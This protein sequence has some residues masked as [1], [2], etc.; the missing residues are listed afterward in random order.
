MTVQENV[1]TSQLTF[2]PFDERGS[3]RI[4][5]HAFLPH[6]RQAGCTYF[7]TFRLADSIPKPVLREWREERFRWL[8]F[9][10]ID[11]RVEGW[12]AKFQKLST[13]ER[14]A[15]ERNYA[16]A[17]FERLDECHGACHLM[18]AKVGEVVAD[19]LRFFDGSRFFLG[20]WVVMPNHVHALMTPSEGYELEN[21]LHSIKSYSATQINKHLGQSGP[22]WMTESYDRLVR[23]SDELLRTQE[24]IC[25]LY[26]SPSPRDKRQSRMPSS[27]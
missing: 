22:F 23:D 13:R 18:K 25:L 14:A 1:P 2:R 16:V 6:V 3:V 12:K 10:G 19:S 9:R 27:A 15:F 4:Y 8:E 7:V 11:I 5:R 26:T 21:V 17:L 20:D 24:Y